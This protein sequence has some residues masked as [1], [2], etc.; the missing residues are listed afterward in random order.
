M[1]YCG[2]VPLKLIR[3]KTFGMFM[4]TYTEIAPIEWQLEFL[5]LSGTW[6]DNNIGQMKLNQKITIPT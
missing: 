3:K 2:W 6:D 1:F 5:P 4:Y